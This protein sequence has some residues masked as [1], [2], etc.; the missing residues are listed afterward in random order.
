[1][2]TRNPVQNCKLLEIGSNWEK[3]FGPCVNT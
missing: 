3:I 2:W 1:M